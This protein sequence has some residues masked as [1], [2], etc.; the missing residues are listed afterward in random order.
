MH[1]SK[2][3]KP[4]Y[5]NRSIITNAIIEIG[6]LLDYRNLFLQ[7]DQLR[8]QAI[9]IRNFNDSGNL[10]K[11][12]DDFKGLS[13]GHIDI[14]T[15]YETELLQQV[16]E[17]NE[18][19]I[20]LLHFFNAPKD[21]ENHIENIDLYVIY[22]SI[23]KMNNASCGCISS[24]NFNLTSNSYIESLEFNS[25][26]N[27]KI[28]IDARGNIKNCPS[29]RESFGNIKDTTLAEAIEK[30]G[31]KK[32]WDINKDKIHVCK[33]CEFRHVCTDCRAYVEDTKDILSKPLKCGYNPYKGEWSEWS[34]NPLKQNA[35]DFYEMRENLTD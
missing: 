15:A 13:V 5:I 21:E 19:R 31:F 8:V 17:K 16:K 27:R 10:L 26:L 3:N 32:Y 18:R 33:D 30:T 25:C 20:K 7:L 22:N 11:L 2:E 1:A 4:K 14:I 12:I 29:M 34:T 28:S 6:D 24:N 35:I 23:K 9:E